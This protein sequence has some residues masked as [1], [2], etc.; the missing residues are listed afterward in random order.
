MVIRMGISDDA[1]ASTTTGRPRLWLRPLI[2]A[3]VV[4]GAWAALV[5]PANEDSGL[6]TWEFLILAAALFAVMVW[7]GTEWGRARMTGAS[8]GGLVARSIAM[9]F[10]AGLVIGSVTFLVAEY[11]VASD[12]PN[13]LG[14]LIVIPWLIIGAIV[15]ALL[16]IISTAGRRAE[17]VS[18]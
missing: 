2:V 14:I 17:P 11:R 18:N 6:A 4:V 15:F 7:R 10:G 8:L 5:I 3:I 13:L 1:G 12:S 9:G 16:C